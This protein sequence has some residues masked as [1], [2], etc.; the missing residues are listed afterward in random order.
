[1][2]K[3]TLAVLLCLLFGI[4][5]IAVADPPTDDEVFRCIRAIQSEYAELEQ[6]DYGAAKARMQPL[7]AEKALDLDLAGMTPYQV[8]QF[9]PLLRIAPLSKD[10]RS[11][12]IVALERAANDD[13]YGAVALLL[14]HS[15]NY[16]GDPDR[17][18]LTRFFAHPK[19]AG[20]MNSWF[21]QHAFNSFGLAPEEMLRFGESIER[22][23]LSVNPN[24]STNLP[25]RVV[26]GRLFDALDHVD[27]AS[28][29]RASRE[30]MHAHILKMARS[31][32]SKMAP[33]GADYSEDVERI[34]GAV[35]LIEFLEGP[36]SS[37]GILNKLA[38]DLKFIWKD[39][40][41]APAFTKL[42]DLKGKVV[43]LD[44]WATWC[45]P[46]VATFPNIRE[47]QAHYAEQ[48]VVIIGVTSIQ[49]AH[50]PIGGQPIVLKDDPDQEMALM[51][52]YIPK[53]D[54]TWNVAFS[55][56]SI[57][58]HRFDIRGVPHLAIVDK[59]GRLRHNGLHPG[60]VTLEEKIKM[61]DALLNEEN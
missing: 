4:S 7:I 12:L 43:I 20:A 55:D 25:H 32:L 48:D 57:D 41:D 46:C 31:A 49:G 37:D 18:Y 10:Q 42:S 13:E 44:F 9:T 51:K 58:D 45:R 11:D 29:N 22:A 38:P 28:T 15:V 3:T 39:G 26:I 30:R 1:M 24:Y 59:Q 50:I 19:M 60:G 2:K 16:R 8:V 36:A 6:S 56:R 40:P 54:V 14:L 61:I 47:L 33:L 35:E 5:N 21:G 34:D 53:N 52:A 27:I 17:Q 23:V